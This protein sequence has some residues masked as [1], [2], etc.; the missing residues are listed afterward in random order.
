MKKSLSAYVLLAAFAVPMLVGVRPASAVADTASA[1]QPWESVAVTGQGRV[2]GRPDRLDASFAVETRATTVAEALKQATVAATRMRDAL[3][4]GGVAKVD[5]QTS[6]ATV[7][8]TRKDDGTITG[9]TANQGLT[10]KIRKLK[11]GGAL[12]SAA[13]TAAG[14]AARLNGVSFAIEDDAA[15]LAEARRK[16][17]ADA[18]TKA[19]LYARAAGRPLGRVV[20]VTESAPGHWGSDGQDRFAADPASVPVEPGLLQ[21]AVT[22]TVE[23]TLEA[24]R[25]QR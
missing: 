1:D 18:R 2:S 3:L 5:L 13:L 6:N 11:R 19:E 23:W 4:R 12:L 17:F 7:V 20:K 24:P 10:A 9:Y 14:D 22:I 25:P 15:L 16:A 8:S 21:L